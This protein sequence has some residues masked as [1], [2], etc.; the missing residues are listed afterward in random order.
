MAIALELTL[1]GDRISAARAYEV[2][3]VN[4]VVPPDEVL[5][6]ALA[7]AERIA[8]NAPLGVAACKDL[9]RTWV[10]DAAAA[11]T[12]LSGVAGDGVRQRGR[13]R[14]RD[15]VRREA[16]PG[17]ASSLTCGPPCAG[18]TG[19]PRSSRSRSSPPRTSGPDRCGSGRPRP[20]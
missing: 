20:R 3:L 17:L 9:V 16:R 18:P 12:K 15:G 6:T 4:A 7:Y 5:P 8:A 19:G 11:A 2:G 10:T 14:G 1:T 13:P